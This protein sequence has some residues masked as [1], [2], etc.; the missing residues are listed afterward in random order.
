MPGFWPDNDSVRTDM[1]DYGYEV[2]YFDSHLV[3]MLDQ[4]EQRGELDNTLVIVTAD[5]GMPFPRVKGQA[6][7]YSNHMPL[8]IMWGKGIRKPGRVL[9]DFISLIDMAPT[10]LEVAGIRKEESGMQAIQGKSLLK[11][12]LHK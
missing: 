12:Y 8:A 10:L 4:L 6:Y 9:D 11:L 5:N 2:G 7:A 3:R 1:L